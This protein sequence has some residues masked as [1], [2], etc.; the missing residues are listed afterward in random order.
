MTDWNKVRDQFPAV[1]NYIYL[2]AASGSPLSRKTAETVINFH[3]EMLEKGDTPWPKW[4]RGIEQVKKKTALLINAHK[5]EIAFM[6]NTS[7]GMG[8][9][10]SML[11]KKGDVLTMKDEFPSS[12]FP[13]INRGY[14]INY[15]K[16]CGAI[17]SLENIR[18]RITKRTGILVSSHVQYCT[19]FKQDL[20]GLGRLCREKGLDFVVNATQSACA[21]PIDVKKSGI[22]FLVFS[23]IKW[24]IAG[25]GAGVLYIGKRHLKKEIY[26]VAGWQS[27]INPGAM[28]NKR[29]DL[30]QAASVLEAGSPL[31]PNILTLGSALDLVL[32]IGIDRIEKRI[33]DLGKYLADR[34]QKRGL[35]MITPLEEKHRSGIIVI[36]MKNSDAIV[37]K[38][39]RKKVVVSQRGEGIRI[40]LHIYNNRKDIDRF[41]RELDR[42]I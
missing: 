8:F 20:I 11:E 37:K 26:P 25:Y 17:Y 24:P 13:W 32:R 30:K 5:D 19:G 7:T 27:V 40:S 31:F 2:N 29:F 42:I 38:L 39:Y 3:K 10:A 9:L 22:D 12:T 41:L 28:D 33:L 16:P 14:R 21:M 23:G 1:R 34:I 15:V 18:K 35:E 6:P 4:L 36:K